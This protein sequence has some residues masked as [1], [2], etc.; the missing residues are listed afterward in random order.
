[1]NHNV[2]FAT[3]RFWINGSIVVVAVMAILAANVGA[4]KPTPPPPV[5]CPCTTRSDGLILWGVGTR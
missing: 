2:H 1:M 3:R 5:E 4:K